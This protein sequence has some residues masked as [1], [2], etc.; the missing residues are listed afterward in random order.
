[1]SPARSRTRECGRPEAQARLVKAE[2]YL[3]YA[4]VALDDAEFDPAAGNAVIAGIA[5]ADAICCVRLGQRSADDDHQ[6]ARAHL[7][8]VDRDAAAALGRLLGVK[9]RA[10]YDH[11]SVTSS[12]ARS[13]VRAART[14][15]EHARTALTA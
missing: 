8:R 9:H 3:R 14:L 4:Q 13:A 7:A 12:A 11:L 6:A 5:A 1:M 10:H 15:I 2:A